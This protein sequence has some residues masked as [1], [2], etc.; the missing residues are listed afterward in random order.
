MPL[1][2]RLQELRNQKGLTQQQLAV[3]ADLSVSA[4]S[5]I[6]QG[7]NTDPRM[8]TLKALAR[9]LGV[10]LDSL[11]SDDESSGPETTK[12]PARRPRK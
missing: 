2:Q 7:T 10:T 11:T 4:V 12:K 1:S 9:A 5:Q 3:A 6:E 8:K